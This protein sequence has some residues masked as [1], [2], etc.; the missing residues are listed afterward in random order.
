MHY[1]GL[2]CACRRGLNSHENAESRAPVLLG[3]QDRQGEPNEANEQP[4]C[5][6]GRRER[7]SVQ[8]HADDARGGARDATRASVKGF[9]A[10]MREQAGE[11][12]LVALSVYTGSLKKILS[13]VRRCKELQRAERHANS[14]AGAADADCRDCSCAGA[15]R[16]AEWF[17]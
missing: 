14:L 16:E 3:V 9:S 11:F 5:S 13:G 1:T 8:T 6:Q 4:D 10:L 12:R 17:A 15:Q 2:K 7:R